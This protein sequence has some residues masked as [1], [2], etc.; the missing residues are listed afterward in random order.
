MI[1][2]YHLKMMMLSLC[3]HRMLQANY[4]LYTAFTLD[5]SHFNMR[6]EFTFHHIFFLPTLILQH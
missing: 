1:A 4:L 6:L 3:S 2:H 5:P